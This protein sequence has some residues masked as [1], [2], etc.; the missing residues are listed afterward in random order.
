MDSITLAKLQVFFSAYRK[1]SFK[2]GDTL[3]RFDDT[4]QG[5][6]FLTRGYVRIFSVSRDGEEL[7][8][9]I[10]KAYDFFPVRWAITNEAVR[11][12]YEALTPVE[13]YRAP[14]DVFLSFL[15]EH[16]DVFYS[17]SERIF[18]R[19]GG[20]MKRIEYLVFGTAE[21]KVASVIQMCGESFGEKKGK[22]VTIDLPLTHREIA[23]L[24]GMTRETVTHAIDD[25]QRRGVIK[26]ENKHIIITDS[27]A[28]ARESQLQ[29]L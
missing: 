20:L 15:H 23:S 17:F 13:T 11:Y 27:E 6:Y 16:P 3:L 25:L 21:N 26:I 10:L 14:K 1:L 22:I 18:L 29:N 2:K 24:V 9:L 28:L 5:V 8:L 19:L 7:T 12:S 4:P